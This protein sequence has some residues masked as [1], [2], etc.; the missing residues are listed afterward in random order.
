ME[1]K[2][3]ISTEDSNLDQ[4]GDIIVEPS[5]KQDHTKIMRALNFLYSLIVAV[6]SGA[7]TKKYSKFHKIIGVMVGL[8]SYIGSRNFVAEEE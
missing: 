7:I 2:T 8:V 1:T 5:K 3:S 6:L 4:S